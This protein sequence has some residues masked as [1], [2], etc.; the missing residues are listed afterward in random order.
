MLTVNKFT[1]ERR[2]EVI[3]TSNANEYRKHYNK[4]IIAIMFV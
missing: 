1:K 2:F 3:L 4:F